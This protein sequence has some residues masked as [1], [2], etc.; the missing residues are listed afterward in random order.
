MKTPLKLTLFLFFCSYFANAQREYVFQKNY[1]T[2]ISI[3]SQEQFNQKFSNVVA[4]P[5]TTA[6]ILALS[7]SLHSKQGRIAAIKEECG[8][9]K[10]GM[11]FAAL[12]NPAIND[13]VRNQVDEDMDADVALPLTHTCGHFKFFYTSNDPDPNNNV[14]LAQIQ[15]TCIVMNNAWD[16]YVINFTTPKH[17]VAGGQQLIDVRVFDLG[18]GLLGSTVSTSNEI[19]LCSKKVVRDDCK[20][21]TTPV[22]ELFHRVQYSYG[23]VSGTPNMKWAVEA[24]ASW[25]QKHRAAAVGDW[26]GRMSG[27]LSDPDKA[28]ITARAYDACHFWTYMG[29]KSLSEKAT[30]KKIWTT[31][32]TNGLNMKAAAN[33]VVDEQN[34]QYYNNFDEF[35]FWWSYANIAKDFN[36]GGVIDY[37]EDELTRVCGG[38]TNGPL[39]HVPRI[40]IN[41]T[42]A[43]NTTQNGSVTAYGADYFELNIGAGVN[44]IKVDVVGASNNFSIAIVEIGA[45]NNIINLRK[46]NGLA[47]PMGG[48]FNTLNYV[49]NPNGLNLKKLVVIIVGNPAGGTYTVK[50]KGAA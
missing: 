43:T 14:T 39:S 48:G 31:Y 21:Q 38:I 49:V 40:P 32:Q 25:S 29:E 50:V 19:K 44:N 26:L 6:S 8:E 20:R 16:D 7:K 9:S 5:K 33:L 3:L 24:M 37:A 47:T 17:Y 2:N 42:T 4:I 22:H 35:V 1:Q 11:L 13:N 30:I 15:A 45:A 10:F 18:A 41:I 28:L 34:S 23:Y 46:A 12:S 27:G 36:S